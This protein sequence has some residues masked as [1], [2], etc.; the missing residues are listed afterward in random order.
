MAIIALEPL[1]RPRRE[2]HPLAW[3][4]LSLIVAAVVVPV[5][6]LID[7]YGYNIDELYF[8]AAGRQPAWGYADQPPLV[9]LLAA[10][11]DALFPGSL[12]ALRLLDL[13]VV[14]AGVVVTAQIAREM[15]GRGRAQVMAAAA[16]A[17]AFLGQAGRL[18]TE[19]FDVVLWMTAGLLVVRWVR[20]R[21]EGRTGRSADLPL[22]WAG[23]V[24]AVAL[25]VKFLIPVFWAALAVSVL[26]VGPRD[27]LRRPA[28]WAGAAI[29]VVA[30]VPG[31]VWQTVHGWPQLQVAAALTGENEMLWG[32][33]PMFLPLLLL[34]TGIPVGTVLFCYGLWALL[35]CPDLRDHRFLGWTVLGVIAVLL[36]AGGRFTYVGGVFPLAF[37]AAAVRMERHR[38]ARWWR[39]T[40]S[41]PVF[42]LAALLPLVQ[43]PITPAAELRQPTTPQERSDMLEAFL[44]LGWPELAN[45]VTLAYNALPPATRDRTTIL[46]RYFWQAGALEVLGTGQGLP[47][48]Y[49][50]HRGYGYLATPPEEPGPVLYVGGMDDELRSMFSG[51]RQVGTV[52][53]RIGLGIGTPIW[54]C[55]GRT[56]AWSRIWPLLKR[57]DAARRARPG[58]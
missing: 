30:T 35:R 18:D 17:I 53:G 15:G 56:A 24:T 21:G 20:L 14:A 44:Q 51:V 50:G 25:Q 37:A 10:L 45:S 57:E 23:V 42:V 3:K 41:R 38:P 4:P 49:S 47:H 54:F 55:E 6:L 32:G 33:R 39:W 16:Y 2:Y 46:T 26:A 31:L 58:S 8:I 36:A 29:A 11:T 28:L 40:V 34:V 43:L 19:T 48:P 52:E 7:G 22:L 5:A 13:L 9:P 27:L 12:L 1:A